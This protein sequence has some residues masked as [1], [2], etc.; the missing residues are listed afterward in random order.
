MFRVRIIGGE[1]AQVKR[2]DADWDDHPAFWRSRGAR[3]WR[4]GP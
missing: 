4:A 2:E 3:R 1:T